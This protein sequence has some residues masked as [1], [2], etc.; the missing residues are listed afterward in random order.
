[1]WICEDKKWALRENLKV[2]L[3]ALKVDFFM[4]FLHLQ[5]QY[6]KIQ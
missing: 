2:H 4:C 6:N 3:F 1:M 5:S